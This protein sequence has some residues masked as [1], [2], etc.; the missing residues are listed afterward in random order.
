MR[1]EK[2]YIMQASALGLVL[3]AFTDCGP[4][5]PNHFT[6]IKKVGLWKFCEPVL[7]VQLGE[8]R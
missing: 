7:V 8:T 1:S 5:K 6:R 4:L 2:N 3:R